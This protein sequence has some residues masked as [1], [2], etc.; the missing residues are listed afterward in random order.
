[1]PY[2]AMARLALK[3]AFS[4]P[5]TSRYPFAPRRIISG[6][7]GQL[8]FTP[9]DCAFCNVCAKKCPTQA[10]VVHRTEKRWS[11]DRLRC[12]SCGYCVEICP[13]DCLQLSTSHGTPVRTRHLE[14]S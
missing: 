6:S 11:I 14:L 7:R 1:M 12:I 3:W 2:F 4:K 9:D 13:K 10:L 8:Q 5:P